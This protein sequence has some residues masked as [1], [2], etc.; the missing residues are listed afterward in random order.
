MCLL[1][2]GIGYWPEAHSCKSFFLN[3]FVA[4]SIRK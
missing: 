2:L 3:E 4:L 1:Y